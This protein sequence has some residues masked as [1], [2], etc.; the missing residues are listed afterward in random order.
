MRQIDALIVGAG[1]AGMTAARVLAERGASVL[2]VDQ[3]EKPGGQL[4]KQIHKFFG[5]AEVC[6][7]VRGIR[8]AERYYEESRRAGAEYCL[9]TAVCAIEP[10][11]EGG[12][13]AVLDNGSR[14]RSRTVILAVGA[15]ENALP[16]PGW[17]L[18]GVMTAGAAQTLVNCRRVAIGRHVVMVGG[19]NV[20]LIVAYQLLQAG[21][22]V[23]CLIEAAPSLGGY[24][25]HAAKLRRAGVP[26]LTQH[27][28]AEVRGRDGVEEVVIARVD[29][30]F[31]M[32]PGS[33]RVLEADTVCLAVGLSPLTGL[34]ELAGCEIAWDPV[35][36][37]RCIRQDNRMM[38]SVPGIFAA[39]D[40]SGVE[41]ASVAI[42]KGAAAGLYAAARLGLMTDEA[43]EA[44]AAPHLRMIETIRRVDKTLAELPEAAAYEGDPT[45]PKAVIECRQGIP[46][47]PCEKNCPA[48][49]I[50]IGDDISR[51]PVVD[52]ARC[53]GCGRCVAMCPGQACFM[54]RPAAEG[55]ADQSEVFFAWEYL[56]LPSAGDTVTACD[57]EGRPVCRARVGSVRTIEAYDRTA[58]VSLIVPS[59][60]ADEVRGLYRGKEADS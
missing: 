60:M 16:F 22:A 30:H 31:A 47:N 42:E 15:G 27:T 44:E 33:E 38:T 26:I 11:E 17:T 21:I 7:G 23:D 3:A 14:V 40:A 52:E 53:I 58:V 37:Q 41:E 57:R 25:V 51:R 4:V 2:T 13:D 39:G 5:S 45:R 55:R 48:G 34:A 18:P 56:P 10:A 59:A 54:I 50:T 46:C 36:R 12:F 35:R 8:L 49:A 9:S 20:G 28:I 24:E 29:E 6:A 32:V 43:A 19:G 1:P